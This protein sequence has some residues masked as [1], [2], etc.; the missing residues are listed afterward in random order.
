MADEGIV[1]CMAKTANSHSDS[2]KCSIQISKRPQATCCAD[3]C[4]AT[5]RVTHDVAVDLKRFTGRPDGR[6]VGDFKQTKFDL[7]NVV[8]ASRT[9]SKNLDSGDRFD[10]NSQRLEE[11]RLSYE[12][13]NTWCKES[14]SRIAAS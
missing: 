4:Y 6:D 5:G 3:N 9:V 10:P 13:N 8:L 1:A 11:Q 2:C 12:V 14:L 7:R